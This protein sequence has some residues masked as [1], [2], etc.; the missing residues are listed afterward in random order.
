MEISVN[1]ARPWVN[2]ANSAI[3]NVLI[4]DLRTANANARTV[5]FKKEFSP[6]VPLNTVYTNPIV[7]TSDDR[8]FYDSSI[9]SGI[10]SNAYVYPVS[11]YHP[12]GAE[13]IFSFSV[14]LAPGYDPTFR[15][16]LYIQVEYYSPT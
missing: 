6:V 3:A 14:N 12:E 11:L 8:P 1:K 4:Y 9:T 10:D 16:S 15:G 13:G 7:I 5:V 2:A